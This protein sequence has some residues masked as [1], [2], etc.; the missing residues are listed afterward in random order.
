MHLM[1]VVCRNGK[2]YY[3]SSC[4]TLDNKYET[5]IFHCKKNGDV[6][7]WND[8]YCEHYPNKS[9]MKARHKKIVAAMKE[10]NR[11]DT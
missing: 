6:T 4:Y 3:V 11:Y 8:L 1:D 7:S 9:V 2:Y 10:G 5:M